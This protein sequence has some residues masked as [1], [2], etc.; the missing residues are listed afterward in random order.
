MSRSGTSSTQ[1]C[2][3]GTLDRGDA[4]TM[5]RPRSRSVRTTAALL[6][7]L[8]LSTACYTYTPPKVAPLAGAVVAFDL[9]DEGRLAHAKALGPGILHV[10]GMLARAEGDQLVVDV[11]EVTPIRGRELPV[12]GVRISVAPGDRTDLRMR[13][14]S[15]K[16]TA[17][18]IGTALAVVVTFLV[19]KGFKAGQTPGEG[20][21]GGGPDQYRG[22]GG[23]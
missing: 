9:T 22:S 7:A 4:S 16:R 14:L 8:Q 1:Y 20:P 15:K 12:S 21:D 10:T 3:T 11:S 19:T 23:E 18:V 5:R 6:A 17:W 2:S 13:T